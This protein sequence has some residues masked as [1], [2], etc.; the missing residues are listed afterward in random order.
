MSDLSERSPDEVEN[1]LLDLLDDLKTN[2]ERLRQSM[3]MGLAASPG[4][5]VNAEHVNAT[6]ELAAAAVQVSRE[7]R[8]WAKQS[9][10]LGKNL[11]REQRLELLLAFCKKLGPNDRR[12]LAKQILEIK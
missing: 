4:A 8:A 6:R 11:S 1:L 3:H 5:G 9:R 10:D 7:A 2:Q 12:A